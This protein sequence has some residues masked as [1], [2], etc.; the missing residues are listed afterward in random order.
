MFNILRETNNV[1]SE[2]NAAEITIHDVHPGTQEGK[3]YVT[4]IIFQ[5]L[6]LADSCRK[7]PCLLC[8]FILL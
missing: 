3:I 6:V 7:F 2:Y 4:F 5:V 8:I 1:G